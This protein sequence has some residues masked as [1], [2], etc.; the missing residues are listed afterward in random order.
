M[1]NS[2]YPVDLANSMRELEDPLSTGEIPWSGELTYLW[3]ATERSAVI[4]L[5]DWS[6]QSQMALGASKL[7]NYC[8]RMCGSSLKS[9]HPWLNFLLQN[10]VHS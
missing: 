2:I 9:N 6:F 3:S 4:S 1:R 5:D 10:Y 8:I 7:Y